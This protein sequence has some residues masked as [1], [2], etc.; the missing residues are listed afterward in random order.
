MAP[1]PALPHTSTDA[2]CILL[3]FG[4]SCP[5]LP[6]PRACPA[7]SDTS[8]ASFDTFHFLLGPLS[9]ALA[10]QHTPLFK[11]FK[12]NTFPLLF[13]GPYRYFKCIYFGSINAQQ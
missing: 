4:G 2:V 7:S 11:R 5:S 1:T 6:T 10:L 8:S 13:L 9:V 12:I 3:V